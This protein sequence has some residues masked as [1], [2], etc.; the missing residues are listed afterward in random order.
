MTALNTAVDEI[1]E[2]TRT[3]VREVCLPAE[4]RFPGPELDGALRDEL[5]EAARGAGVFAPHVPTEFGG[6]GLDISGWS[7][8]F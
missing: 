4:S 7:V 2:R 6:L 8:V 1:A 5:Q 3:F